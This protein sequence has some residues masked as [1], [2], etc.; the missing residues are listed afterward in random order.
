[1]R[2]SK[3]YWIVCPKAT[4]AL[5]KIV[6]FRDWLLAEASTDSRRLKRLWPVIK[7][8]ILIFPA[9]AVFNPPIAANGAIIAVVTLSTAGGLAP[10]GVTLLCGPVT[11]DLNAL[12]A[13][14]VLFA[15]LLRLLRRPLGLHRNGLGLIGSRSV[16]I[17]GE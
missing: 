12:A 16:L 17:F 5:P 1:M 7:S 8:S 13:I 3:T 15:G 14:P 9:R 11:T 2:L 10:V 6:T 4:A